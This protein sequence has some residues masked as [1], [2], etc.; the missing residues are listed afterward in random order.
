MSINILYIGNK[1][2][3]KGKSPSGIDTLGLLL[4]NESYNLCYSSS[5]ENKIERLFD[6]VFAVVK[7]SKKVVYILIDSYSTFGFWYLLI[8][9]QLARIL[10]IKYIPILHG[11]NLPNRL[12]N[13]PKLS[14]LIFKNAHINVAPSNY[15][16]SKFNDFGIRNLIYIP[17]TIEIINYDFIN[18]DLLIPNILWVRSLSKIYNPQMAIRVFKSIKNEYPNATLTMV[19]EDK[20]NLKPILLDLCKSLNVEV[21]FTGK[22]SKKEWIE[23]SKQ[24]NIFI[25]TTH[26]DNTPVSVIEA[27][28]L[29]LPVVSTNVGGIPYLL[30][31][32]ENALLVDDNDEEEMVSAIKKLLN[33]EKFKNIIVKNARN[34]VEKFDWDNVKQKWFE[35]LR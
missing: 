31:D 30:T 6:M 15:L 7:Y 17:N 32:S 20:E 3:T 19:G 8:C 16:L 10:N 27:M 24:Y 2:S 29:G 9:S 25:N 35:L 21:N 28:A 26:L 23:L 11:G 5:K 22:L 18:R 12:K 4:E 14:N 13:N 34:L 1:L 33:D